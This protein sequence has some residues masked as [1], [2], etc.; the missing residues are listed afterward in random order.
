VDLLADAQSLTCSNCGSGDTATLLAAIASI[1]VAIATLGVVVVTFLAARAAVRS[2]KATEGLLATQLAPRLINMVSADG[3]LMDPEPPADS[4]RRPI[5]TM[6]GHLVV[7][8][9]NEHERCFCS[10]PVRNVGA[11][12]ARIRSAR[13]EVRLRGAIAPWVSTTLQ[14]WSTPKRFLP[15]GEGTRINFEVAPPEGGEDA[16]V[17]S[18]LGKQ[19]TV[20]EAFVDA[21]S[22]GSGIR[23]YLRSLFRGD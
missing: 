1:L 17:M 23:L 7:T 3:A 11:G 10:V 22:R 8:A 18:A 16:Q 13:I 20:T 5:Q 14:S 2:A 6:I 15:S 4:E 9:S 21:V 19:V 12:L